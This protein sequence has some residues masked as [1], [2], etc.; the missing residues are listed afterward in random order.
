MTAEICSCKGLDPK[1][2]KCFGSGYV[3]GKGSKKPALNKKDKV[4]A[5]TQKVK[6]ESSL[7][8]KVASMSKGEVENLAVEIIT[9][10]DLKSK[11]QLQLLNSIPFSTN[12]FRRDFKEKFETLE[13][14]ER[15]KRNLRND[16]DVIDQ[17]IFSKK[18][19]IKL[20]FKH[21]LSDK[22]I[23]ITSNRQLKELIREY[24]K[25]KK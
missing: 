19:P 23:D 16:L 22:D 11:K 20:R 5:Q 9:N 10:L 1:C 17:E 15:E 6:K 12:T 24:K 18:Y 21:F 3:N 8:E 25:L 4:S 2:E 13:T 14:L 7:S